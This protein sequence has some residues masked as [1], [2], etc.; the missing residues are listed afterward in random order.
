MIIWGLS[1]LHLSFSRPK[2]MDVFGAH[3]TRH[4]ERIEKAWRERV[5]EEDVVCLPGDLSWAMRI[6][7]VRE[8]LAWLGRLP[9]RKVLVKGNHDYWWSSIGKVRTAL[10]AGVHALQ[11]DA[12][13]LGGVT[14]AGARGWVDSS[15]DFRGLGGELGA[16]GEAQPQFGIRGEEEDARIYGRELDRLEASLQRMDSKAA[17][18]VALLHFPPTSPSLEDTPVTRL[19]ESYRVDMALF[20]H[21]HGPGREAFENPYGVKQGTAYYL[22]S[23]DFAGFAPVKVAAIGPRA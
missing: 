2:P 20:G 19:L 18:R 6:S 1:D 15:L 16:D 11:N 5:G 10:P 23:A 9:G 4:P 14:F 17:L 12:L 3:W 22:V 13:S 8:E 21:L 7:E